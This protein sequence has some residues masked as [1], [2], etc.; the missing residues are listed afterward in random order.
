MVDLLY[1]DTKSVG[2]GG[3]GAGRGLRIVS[4]MVDRNFN[5]PSLLNSNNSISYNLSKTIKK[6]LIDVLLLQ[7]LLHAPQHYFFYYHKGLPYRR[8]I[9]PV[10]SSH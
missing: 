4:L 7:A 10:S 3:W 2:V 1:S 6:L 5:T 8:V 9:V